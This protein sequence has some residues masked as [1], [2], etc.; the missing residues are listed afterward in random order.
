M[1]SFSSLILKCFII[2][3]KTL[4]Y[5]IEYD[6]KTKTYSESFIGINMNACHILPIDSGY[7]RWYLL[8]KVDIIYMVGNTFLDDFYLYDRYNNYLGGNHYR[9]QCYAPMLS[10]RHEKEKRKTHL[11]WLKIKDFFFLF[12]INFA[13]FSISGTNVY[14]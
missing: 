1:S 11:F 2:V 6:S 10:Y 8:L 4:K 12:L 5:T 13:F 7:I 3:L 9:H 14:I